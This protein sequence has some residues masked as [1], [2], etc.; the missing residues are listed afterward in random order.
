[1]VAQGGDCGGE[2]R[3][4]EEEECGEGGCEGARLPDLGFREGLS[5]E[6]ERKSEGKWPGSFATDT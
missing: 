1:M 2:R 5:E 4:A 3:E 6:T